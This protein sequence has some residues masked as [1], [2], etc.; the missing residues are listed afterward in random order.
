MKEDTRELEQLSNSWTN[1]FGD[2]S[3]ELVVSAFRSLCWFW[4]IVAAVFASLDKASGSTLA[5]R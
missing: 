4:C 3:R 1:A 5:L 2:L